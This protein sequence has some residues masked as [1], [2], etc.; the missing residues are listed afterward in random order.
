MKDIDDIVVIIQA[1][2][3]SE[4]VPQKMVK[5]FAGTTL[6]EICL[7]KILSS[8][9]VPKRNVYASVHEQELVDLAIDNGSNVFRRSEKSAK[10][11]GTPITEIYEWWDQFHDKKYCVL[12]NACCPMLEVETID[13]FIEHY[14]NTDSRGLFG[15]MEKKNYFWNTDGEMLT[16]WPQEEAVMN[17]KVVGKTLEAAH[18]LYAGSLEAIGQGIW[19]GDFTKGDP[20]LYV[21]PEEQT[22]DIDYPWQ[23]QAYEA[24][25][26]AKFGE[27]SAA[28]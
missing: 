4:R 1:R 11:E 21:V 14:M 18:C 23:F 5:P 9:V 2:L 28:K 7:K 16:T 27:Q 22:L 19:M 13:K 3:S 10:S 17:T 25:Y 6:Y 8:K 24:V 15:V 26:K 20:E 12:V